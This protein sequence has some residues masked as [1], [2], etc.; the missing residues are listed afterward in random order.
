MGPDAASSPSPVKASVLLQ[1][2]DFDAKVASFRLDAQ[3]ASLP[4]NRGPHPAS[5]LLQDL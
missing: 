1:Q 3:R 2:S 5:D 4:A